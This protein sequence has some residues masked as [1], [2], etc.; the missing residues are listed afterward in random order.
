VS[1]LAGISLPSASL[2]ACRDPP[3]HA[4][5]P[6]RSISIHPAERLA[7][8]GYGG[9]GEVDASGGRS[10]SSPAPF[11][12]RTNRPCTIA[13]RQSG[14]PGTSLLVAT[15]I[16][17]V[18]FLIE[19]STVPKNVVFAVPEPCVSIGAMN[20]VRGEGVQA[21]RNRGGRRWGRF[22]MGARRKSDPLLGGLVVGLG[23]DGGRPGG[24]VARG[25]LL[26]C[27]MEPLH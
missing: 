14:C 24:V 5:H 12:G 27:G 11:A 2:L 16:G 15:I 18:I 7:K 4:P 23:D 19:G 26:E 10:R 9:G 6:F 1:V 8:P 25:V 20:G 17:T 3:P 21:F 13:R 22:D